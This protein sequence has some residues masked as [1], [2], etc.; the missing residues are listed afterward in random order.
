[1][2]VEEI[3]VILNQLYDSFDMNI[4]VACTTASPAGQGVHVW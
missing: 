2:L 4:L 1:M 3:K